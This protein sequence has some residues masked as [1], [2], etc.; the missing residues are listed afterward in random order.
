[1]RREILFPDRFDPLVIGISSCL[2]GRET[3]YD[4]AHSAI[5]HITDPWGREFAW[6]PVCPE[7]EMGLPA[8]RETLD[9][10]GDPE[11]PRLVHTES[12]KDMTAPMREMIDSALNQFSK[13]RLRGFILRH[14]SPSCGVDDTP[15]LDESGGVVRDG[16]PGLFT[17]ALRARFPKLPVIDDATLENPAA[18]QAFL[19]EVYS[20]DSG[21]AF[22]PPDMK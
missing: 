17:A 21:Y 14:G 13:I 5:P 18:R 11:D 19:A 3:R 6:A 7:M 1:M 12:R 15:V 4:G 10:V 2:L 16:G 8:P 20:Y 9:L 22:L